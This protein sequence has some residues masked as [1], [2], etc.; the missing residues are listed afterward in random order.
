LLNR[1]QEL[2]VVQAGTVGNV[3][4]IDSAYLPRLPVKPRKAL[5]L[6]LGL[7][8]GA[9]L[10]VFTVFLRQVLSTGIH[11]PELLEHLF[12]L[13]VYAILPRSET[14]R[15]LTRS[16]NGVR[17]LAVHDPQ[18]GAV[19][20]LRSLRTSLE[21]L[22]R[23]S[24]KNIVTIGGPAPGVGKSFVCSNLGVLVAQAGKRV[25]VV[26]ADM[27]RGHLH[28]KFGTSRSPGLSEVIGDGLDGAKAVRPTGIENL[29]FLPGGSIP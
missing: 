3:R 25:L 12:Q 13:P 29:H 16:D 19:E 2:K 4:I 1:A 22:I 5:I 28:R 23:E 26:D 11:D 15:R 17:L 24:G 14:E 18:E 10:G 27:R 20:S 9:M 6:A 21:F 8:L 7:V